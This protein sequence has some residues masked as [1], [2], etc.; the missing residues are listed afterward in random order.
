MSRRRKMSPQK[1]SASLAVPPVVPDSAAPA[2]ES[3][4]LAG[5]RAE[6]AAR[7]AQRRRSRALRRYA[8]AAVVVLVLVGAAYAY[9]RYQENLP[10]DA[11]TQMRSPHIGEKESTPEYSTDPPTSGPHLQRVAEWGI[12]SDPVSKVEMV[13]NLED[14]GVVISYRPDLDKATVDQLAKLADSYDT[15]VLMAPYLDL[16]HPIVLTAWRRIDR[17]DQLDEGRIR[18]FVDA[19]RGMDHHGESGS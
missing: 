18:S 17:L 5:K 6:Q 11:V 3:P 8:L 1:R 19:Y 16:S 10:G 9:Y 4:P 2:P 7:V 14:G 15:D 13:H 12:R